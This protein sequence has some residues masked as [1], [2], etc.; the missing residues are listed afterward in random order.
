MIR[1]TEQP[2]CE[3]V[4]AFWSV[5]DE[6]CVA[7][8][9]SAMRGH[10]DARWSYVAIDPAAVMTVENGQAKLT[11]RGCKC[12]E[13]DDWRAAFRSILADFSAE[14]PAA[15]P[16]F[17]GGWIGWLSYELGSEFDHIAVHDGTVLGAPLLH[18][19]FYDAVDAFDLEERRRWRVSVGGEASTSLDKIVSTV[20]TLTEARPFEIASNFTEQT[21]KCAVERAI[22]LINAGDIYQVNLS[23]QFVGQ[24]PADEATIYVRLRE[25][26]PAPYSAFLQSAKGTLISSSPEL[27]MDVDA[28]AGIVSSRPIKGTRPRGVT[29][30]QD[31]LNAKE[32][33]DSAK[34]RAE[35]IMIVDLVRNDLGRICEAG[36]VNTTQ[37]CR[38]EIHPTVLHLVSTVRGHLKA[39]LDVIDALGALFPGG[40][41]TGAPKIRACEIIKELESSARGLYTGAYGYASLSGDAK[42]AMSIRMIWTTGRQIAYSVGGGI[43]ADSDPGWEY[44]ETLVKAAAIKAALAG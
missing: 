13:I 32:L 10:T 7:F 22:E 31:V 38:R 14:I 23:Q 20:P 3:P 6:P 43:V 2:W 1:V 42:F 36:S 24:A 26:S 17:C 30:D 39:G 19:A 35:N 28:D 5:K 18:L 34:D 16:S 25:K 12:Q 40:S 33:S 37:I 21:Y 41:V 44:Q 15:A 4:N 9:D 29:H 27:F 11:L 8:L